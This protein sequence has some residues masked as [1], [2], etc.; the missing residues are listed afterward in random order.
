MHHLQ[1]DQQSVENVVVCGPSHHQL[2][3]ILWRLTTAERKFQLLGLSLKPSKDDR[4][5]SL[6]DG[7]PTCKSITLNHASGMLQ[8][9][10]EKK[11]SYP[12]E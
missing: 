6:H 11:N 2:A 8:K 1:G 5:I 10:H 7:T 12:K 9:P 4:M 3:E